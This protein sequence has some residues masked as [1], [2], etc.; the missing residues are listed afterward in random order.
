LK[1]QDIL[2]RL[3]RVVYGRDQ[4]ELRKVQNVISLIRE[5]LPSS[6]QNYV[7][8]THLLQDRT[9]F[10]VEEFIERQK[11]SFSPEWS[12]VFR[13]NEYEA[14]VKFIPYA[15]R[16]LEVLTQNILSPD[17]Y[18][19]TV[20]K[21]FSNINIQDK[22]VTETLKKISEKYDFQKR[23]YGII[24]NTLLYGDWF[25]E[26]VDETSF[27]KNVTQYIS[28]GDISLSADVYYDL[29][30]ETTQI[31]DFENVTNGWKSS[32]SNDVS[33]KN[34]KSSL[35]LVEYHPSRVVI[36]GSEEIV[37]GYLVFPL[38]SEDPYMA[39]ALPRYNPFTNLTSSSIRQ[40][41]E[42]NTLRQNVSNISKQF[43]RNI[44]A[45]L[46]KSKGIS[47]SNI[48][49]ILR[50]SDPVLQDVILSLILS[51]QQT[52]QKMNVRFV[53]PSKMC[54]F[55]LTMK[56]G[57][58]LAP[59][60]CSLLYGLNHQARVLIS[61]SSSIVMYRL[62]RSIERRVF[63]VETGVSR[64]VQT[65]IQQIIRS[66]SRRRYALTDPNIGLEEIPS[67]ISSFEDI[68]IPMKAG[69]RFIETDVLPSGN[70]NISMD[71]WKEMRDTF[72]AGL[73]V[74]PAYLNIEQN[75]ETRGTL[76]QENIVFA[77]TV[78]NYQLEFGECFTDMIRKIFRCVKNK[79]LPEEFKITFN[80][81]MKLL[82]ERYSEMV[83]NFSQ[84]AEVAKQMGIDPK[85]LFDK[86]F[87]E[88]APP[89]SIQKARTKKIEDILLGRSETE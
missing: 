43:L 60:G 49:E 24:H 78:L 80:P 23:A 71:D 87:G 35:K 36:L 46:S 52:S 77:I 85:Q 47:S 7:D 83:S 44:L 64:D 30:E 73:G 9:H 40:Y 11:D 81:P 1:P 3:R 34:R 55:K 41:E 62:S 17:D 66:L 50:K 20:F 4:D 27:K 84:L 63:H 22:T 48:D 33:K 2:S 39:S 58:K 19:K 32:N 72:I 5:R 59:Y 25:V 37:L 53:P 76:A 65:P 75:Y 13:Y 15:S 16:A 6:I 12:R 67:H 28:E 82:L 38:F 14:I 21:N 18:T 31:G 57:R 69:K 10:S 56:G 51:T 29:Y 26:L 61:L 70:L 74:P 8:I 89:E 42:V 45:N 86:F 68:F 54:H 79:D 88:L